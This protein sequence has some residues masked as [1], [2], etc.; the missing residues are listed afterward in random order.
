MRP[1]AKYLS[2][3]ESGYL[4]SY[5]EQLSLAC[6]NELYVTAE[7]EKLDRKTAKGVKSSGHLLWECIFRLTS[8][9]Q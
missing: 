5:N 3:Y 4:E 8:A 1:E 2:T 7:N 9:Y 6:D